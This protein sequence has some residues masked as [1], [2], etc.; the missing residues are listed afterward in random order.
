[1]PVAHISP[2]LQARPTVALPVAEMVLGKSALE[3][4]ALLPRL[5]NLCRV[6]QGVAARAAF[7]LAQ[8]PGWQDALRLEILKE[9]VAKVALKWPGL[10]SMA[11]LTLPRDWAAGGDALRLAMFGPDKAL[12]KSFDGFRAFLGTDMGMAPVLQAISTLFEPSWAIRPELLV[13]TT[14]TLFTDVPQENS[15]AG[16]HA[17]HPVMIGIE[18]HWGRGPLWSATAVAYDMQACLDRRLPAPDL[19]PGRAVV[20]AARG[21]YGI[22]ARVENGRV[23]QFARITPTDHLLMADGVLEHALGSLPA[24]CCTALAPLLLSILDPCVPVQLEPVQM[25]EVAHA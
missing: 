4:A 3:A 21:L 25:Q 24:K 17:A 9:H 12:P 11:P 2:R 20:P 1:M 5:F 16:R 18:T 6:A 8:E 22:T 7:S 15:V 19:T 23:M 14:N 13:T 10:M